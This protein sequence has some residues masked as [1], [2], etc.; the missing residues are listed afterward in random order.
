MRPSLWTRAL[1]CA[2]AIAAAYLV[3][4][5]LFDLDDA[6]IALHG[7]EVAVRGGD[8]VY[9]APALA[10]A[11]SPAYVGML[12]GALLAGFEGLHA[13]RLV[14]ALGL[15]AF[16]FALLQL[17]RA[18][19]LSPRRQALLLVTTL[20]SG[21]VLMQATNGLETGWALALAT[22]LIAAVASTASLYLTAAGAALLPFLR[23][24]LLPASALLLLYAS[25]DAAWRDRLKAVAIALAV[26]APLVLWIRVDTGAW[27][28]QTIAAKQLFFAQACGELPLK[29]AV[30]FAAVSRF[31]IMVA[32][33]AIGTI[34]L[35]R[36]RL[37]RYGA[38]ACAATLAAFVMRFP[39]GVSHNDSRYLY[40]ILTPWLSYG[41][42]LR[43]RDGGLLGSMPA[44]TAIAVATCA[45][46]PFIQ[47]PRQAI[48]R[49]LVDAAVWVDTNVPADAVVLVHDAG[50][51]STFAH[52]RAVDL[53]GLK[54][55]SSIEAHRRLTAPSCGRDRQAAIADIAAASHASYAVLVSDW[56]E[57]FEI[58]RGLEAHGFVLT[59]LRTPPSHARG[60]T[61]YRLE[62]PSAAECGV[63]RSGFGVPGSSV[64]GSCVLSSSVPGFDRS[65][66]R[67]QELSNHNPHNPE[68]EPEPEPEPRTPNAERRTRFTLRPL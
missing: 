4:P 16:A 34:A 15:A 2:I 5:A 47:P 57:T 44:L 61:V 64:P 65:Q 12:I 1:A 60:Y 56:D 14:S 8:A 26:S 42:A 30:V 54:T 17:G 63:R 33:L 45:A 67:F 19:D 35:V 23:P 28:P 53:V 55:A 66:D 59:P 13:L 24:E 25:R 62:P 36:D 22:A 68:P 20:G 21:L 6:Y 10:G 46:W 39:A 52:R 38:V 50:A 29:A 58:R 27:V 31:L 41:V 43:L 11:T 49:E 7:A 32:P 51:I 18:L 3:T 48:A 37:G 9:G 40:A